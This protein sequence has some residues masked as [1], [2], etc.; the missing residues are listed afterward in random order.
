[1]QKPTPPAKARIALAIEYPLLQ[2]GGVE[3]L[4]QYL[5][6]RLSERYE[7][8]LVS[9]DADRASLGNFAPHVVAHHS[10][11]AEDVDRT[12][13][14]NLAEKLKSDGVSLVHF[15]GGE[16][17]WECGKAWRSPIRYAGE[18]GMLCVM[19]THLMY[20]LLEGYARLDR[21]AWQRALLLPKAWLSKASLL[22]TLRADILVSK[23]DQAQLRSF[24]P[25]QSGKIRQ[26]Y[27]SRLTE[28]L[29]GK[30]IEERRKTI[31]C[32]GAICE[33][34]NQVGL[35]RAFADVAGKHPEW[36]LQLVGRCETPLC[37]DEVQALV[38]QRDLAGRVVVLPPQ[39]D[40]GP[41][42]AEA[43]VFALPSLRE[44]LPLSLQ[45]ALYY[46]CACVA[47]D[48]GGI[49]EL[50]QHE[51][52]GLLVEPQDDGALARALDRLM[53]DAPLRIRLGQ[54]GRRRVIDQGMSAEAMLQNHV[55]LYDTLLAGG[56]AADV[57]N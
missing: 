20:P 18:A 46:E 37:L 31:L 17:E 19:T 54:A 10:W 49:R 48:L 32:L 8:V 1:M 7:V 34:K 26:M 51:V 36:V 13:A 29:Q 28:G 2:Q 50:V 52:N 35:V 43:S 22:R 57:L 44:G 33:R 21:P 4:L 47:S 25:H 42:L 45:E 40:P 53:S 6:P 12:A 5:I 41:L 14:R 27:H 55:R 9:K 15:H 38:A 11:C 24:Y 3:V 30:P 16:F 23:R 56:K 39:N